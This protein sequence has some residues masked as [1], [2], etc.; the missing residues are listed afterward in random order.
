VPTN[1]GTYK[2]EIWGAQGGGSWPGGNTT[3]GYGGYS[4]GN[5][6]LTSGQIIYVNVGQS[7]GTYNGGGI[8]AAPGGGATHIALT[9]RGELKNYVSYQSEVVIVAGGGGGLEWGG[10]GGDGGG[11]TGNNGNSQANSIF[12]AAASGTGG[13]QSAGGISTIPLSSVYN[14]PNTIVNGSFG[15][16]GYGYTTDGNNDYGA[17]GG[18]GWY[19]G[20]GTSYAGAGGGGSGHL[21]SMLSNSSM[22]SGVQ[23]GDGYAKI[24]QISF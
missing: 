4:Y 6:K 13:T 8:G 19:G 10:K 20:G 2:L 15:Q 24:T 3:D 23:L 17:G 14:G 11:V 9:N 22:Q 7:S 12:S 21:G 5:L 1:V 16:G 18:G